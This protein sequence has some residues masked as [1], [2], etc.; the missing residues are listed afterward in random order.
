MTGS[1]ILSEGTTAN[2]AIQ[3]R[4]ITAISAFW[5]NSKLCKSALILYMNNYKDLKKEFEKINS[6][7]KRFDEYI[8]DNNLN[9]QDLRNLLNTLR[10]DFTRLQKDVDDSF[11]NFVSMERFSLTEKIVFGVVTVVLLGFATVVVNF[12]IKQP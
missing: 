8:D 10:S 3:S 4:T 11:K 2:T 1:T 7:L 5:L 12:F 6:E 9:R